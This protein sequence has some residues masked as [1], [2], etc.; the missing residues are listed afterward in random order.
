MP[1]GMPEW[2]EL[3]AATASSV[4][5]RMAAALFQW[6]GFAERS[7][8]IS[9]G[10][11]SF[12]VAYPAPLNISPAS[13]FKPRRG[14]GAR[15]G[16]ILVALSLESRETGGTGDSPREQE[17][18]QGQ[19]HMSD[20]D[21]FQRRI[22]AALDRIGQGLETLRPEGEADEADTLRQQLEDEKLA[23]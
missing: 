19:V 2:P 1:I 11:P 10:C 13:K 12:E 3:A 6:S 15:G 16:R 7:E 21:E 20:I 18:G 22:T 17:A 9:T 5:A 8:A 4:S 23:N 14:R